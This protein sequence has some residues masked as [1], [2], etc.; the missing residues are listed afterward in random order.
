M[1]GTSLYIL[2]CST[3]NRLRKRVMRLREPRYAVGA[4]AGL[5]YL[6]FTIGA[7]M[8]AGA[9]AA[10]SAPT[11]GPGAEFWLT[12]GPAVGGAVL[13]VLAAV[14]AV[15]PISTKSLEFSRSETEFLLPAPLSTLQ[16]LVY[17]LVRSQSGVFFGAV[18]V[19]LVY[20]AP[21]IA[22]RAIRLVGLFTLLSTIRFFS[23]GVA[24]AQERMRRAG[25]RE[26]PAAR[27]PLLLWVLAAAIV[28]QPVVGSLLRGG[29]FDFGALYER[30]WSAGPAHWVLLPFSWLIRPLFDVSFSAAVRD[31]PLA[32]LV[33]VVTI[34]WVLSGRE[35]FAQICDGMSDRQDAAP[36][37]TGPFRPTTYRAKPAM[38]ALASTGRP[39]AAFAW[40]GAQ[41]MFRGVNRRAWIRMIVL[42]VWLAVV[43]SSVGRTRG[44]AQALGVVS[45]LAT[46]IAVLMGPQIY[47]AD[48]RQDLE[49]LDLLKTWP[50]RPGSVIRG[51]MMW[52]VTVVTGFAWFFAL[53]ALIFSSTLFPLNWRVSIAFTALLMAPVLIIA[54]Y[55]VHA[56]LT[57]L[58]PAWI[59]TGRSMPRGI[60]AMGQRMILLGGTWL[61]LVIAVLPGAI[62]GGLLWLAFYSVIGPWFLLPTAIIGAVTT[63]LEALMA[64]EALG[65]LYERL[66]IAGVER[67]D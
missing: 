67:P 58:F 28:L 59:P 47:R 45:M 23:L 5:A 24:L 12:M 61:T 65:P 2:W 25:P 63:T 60:D 40:K 27:A 9:R 64:T 7:R 20:P 29:P 66:D 39:E 43:A 48:L 36:A 21:S 51:E 13:L 53:L 33:C 54:Q 16:L 38:W 44:I 52:P 22:A 34:G 3:R 46:A 17:R 26:R 42:I 55:T 11:D 8:R 30:A 15:L 1:I 4:V 50:V 35:T 6:Y 37:S 56:T 19:A 31:I 62:V 10:R 14:S 41:Q 18:I 32:L 49:H 57:L